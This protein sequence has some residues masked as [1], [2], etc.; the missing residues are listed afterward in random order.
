MLIFEE[1]AILI[2][3]SGRSG[4]WVILPHCHLRNRLEN[5]IGR[6]IADICCEIHEDEE[7]AVGGS[8]D[9]G[10]DPS[11]T[12]I[13]MLRDSN[14]FCANRVCTAAAT[15]TCPDYTRGQITNKQRLYD[16]LFFILLQ[17][18]SKYSVLHY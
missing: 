11:T 6:P 17:N 15:A 16:L 18:R 8:C 1:T 9:A 14:P 10:C 3:R 12:G 5:T 7:R 2:E 4:E 13:G